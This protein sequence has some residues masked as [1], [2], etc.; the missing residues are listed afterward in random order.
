[1][2]QSRRARWW[3]HRVARRGAAHPDLRLWSILDEGMIMA[4]NIRYAGLGYLSAASA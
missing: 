4:L 1:M 2:M 3:H